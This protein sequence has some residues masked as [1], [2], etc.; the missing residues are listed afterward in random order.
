MSD[1]IR[2][3]VLGLATRGELTIQQ[4]DYLLGRVEEMSPAEADLLIRAF[5][6]ENANGTEPKVEP[7]PKREGIGD[8]IKG[9]TD[10]FRTMSADDVKRAVNEEYLAIE[11]NPR[12][13]ED[14][15]VT[16]VITITAAA[17]AGVTIQPIP[18]VEFMLFTP[19]QCVMASKIS[20][21]RGGRVPGDEATM[22]ALKT[23][24]GAVGLSVVTQS[25]AAT[26]FKI[27]APGIGGLVSGPVMY[28]LTYG[29]GRVM[30]LYFV[31]RA[32]GRPTRKGDLR[33][34]FRR[35]RDEGDRRKR[36]E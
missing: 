13:T 24:M 2:S 5:L 4:V 30:D 1:D 16:R 10:R 33:D 12:Y 23:C 36:P 11:Q 25:A 8:R 3:R 20:N 14:E 18:L 17:C 9:F 31:D 21:I 29:V 6:A 19:L 22:E 26:I 7:P 27:G 32:A 35:G 15:K 34:A 28:G